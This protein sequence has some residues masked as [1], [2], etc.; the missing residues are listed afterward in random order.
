M[1]T[2]R[3]TLIASSAPALMLLSASQ[4]AVIANQP[5]GQTYAIT[6]QHMPDVLANSAQ[7]YDDFSLDTT[8][9][10]SAL[11]IYGVENGHPG[12]NISVVMQITS[13]VGIAA[14][15]LFTTTG[16]QVGENLVFD[17]TGMQ[18][19][20]G[21][22]WLSAFVVRPILT[23]GGQ[24][25]WGESTTTNGEPAMWQNPGNGY[26]LGST[27]ILASQFSNGGSAYD[28]A[29]ILKGTAAPAPGALALLGAAGLL[30]SR[31]RRC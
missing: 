16:T 7:A 31:R 22:Y 20:A 18:L 8:T 12:Y 14:P 30:G 29:F 1:N 10:L 4:A 17:L 11:T 5:Y 19:V 26:G 2:S 13:S 21:H 24:W 27:P 28:M 6:S 9:D 15:V 23:G 3:F 25:F